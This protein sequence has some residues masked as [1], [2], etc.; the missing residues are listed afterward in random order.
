MMG[1]DAVEE[2]VAQCSLYRPEALTARRFRAQFAVG[3]KKGARD[4]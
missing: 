1:A 3:R 4:N 2:Q